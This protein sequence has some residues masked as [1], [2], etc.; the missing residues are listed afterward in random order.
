M[1]LELLTL[2]PITIHGY[3][4]M[5]GLGVI[6][7]MAL[8]AY[9][10]KK[11]GI[12]NE[13]IVLDVAIYGLLAGFLGAKL[14]YVFV[15]FDQFLKDPM[16]V[17]GSEGF[18]VYGGIVLGVAAAMVYCRI[19]KIS[20]LECFDLLCASISLAQGFG[21]IGC[22]L[23]GC[24]YGRE[25]TS[26][27]GV[28]F[29]EGCMAPAGVKLLPTQLMSSAGD[30]AITA[31]LIWYYKRRKHLGDV[32]ALYMILY[33]VGRFFLEFL[34]SDDRGGFGA[35]STSQWISIVIVA[36]AFVLMWNNR[37]RDNQAAVEAVNTENEDIDMEKED[38]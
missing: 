27:F 35:L 18:V 37:K 5:I 6:A 12:F 9:R 36:A 14:L 24:C 21:R 23:A 20:F 10:A 22:F 1:K 33:G 3:G 30:F 38:E 17:L 31:I 4:F 2:G 13:E 28:V 34:R 11:T 29:P 25:T 32:G 15:E 16:S 7:C 19:K 8:G 26:I